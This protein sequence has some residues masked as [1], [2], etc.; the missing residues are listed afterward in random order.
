MHLCPVSGNVAGIVAGSVIGA[1]ALI[2][3]ITA[4]ILTSRKQRR[5]GTVLKIV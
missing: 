2:V 5:C 1:L 3:I 4:L